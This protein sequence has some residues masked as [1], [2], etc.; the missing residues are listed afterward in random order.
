MKLAWQQIPST[1]ISE[2][3]SEDFEGVVLDTEHGC[4]NNET[5]YNCIQIITAKRKVCLVRLTEINRTLIR[6][7]LDAGTSGLIFSTIENAT[8]ASEIKALCAYPKYGGKRGL[9]LVRQNKWGYSTLVNK[10]PIIVAPI[11]TKEG[12]ENLQEIYAEDLDYYMIGPYDLSA[13]LGITAE[14]DNPKFIEAIAKVKETIT[15]TKQMAVHIPTDV[16][17]HID[18]YSEYGIIAVGMDTTILLEGYK[19]L[20]NA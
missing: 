19:E 15:N 17:K 7:C 11:E 3:L 1:I 20:K 4:F 18:N 6:A 16:S 13:S 9:G 2:M 10:P 14:F 12:I 8:Q 5:L